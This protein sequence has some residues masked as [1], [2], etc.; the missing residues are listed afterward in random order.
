MTEAEL[1]IEW[2]QVYQ[3]RVGILCGD[4]QPNYTQD[5]I[6]RDEATDH[7]AKLREQEK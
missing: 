3:T 2:E 4:S 5:K 1:K 6:A 7:V